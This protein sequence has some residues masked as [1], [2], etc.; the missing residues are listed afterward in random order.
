[1]GRLV[2]YAAEEAEDKIKDFART[3]G[4]NKAVE[5]VLREDVLGSV[6]NYLRE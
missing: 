2:I 4:L 5:D 1:M 3:Y 6:D